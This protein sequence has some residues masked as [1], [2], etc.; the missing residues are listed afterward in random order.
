MTLLLVRHYGK[1]TIIEAIGATSGMQ[2]QPAT[3]ARAY[4]MSNSDETYVA[5]ATTY[6]VAMVGKILI[7]QLL[8]I[9]ANLLR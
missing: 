5:Y 6:P 1:S 2:T 9:I 3:L 8:V 7:A 4:E